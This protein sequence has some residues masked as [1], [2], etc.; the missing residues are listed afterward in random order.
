MA[1]T[2]IDSAI[3]ARRTRIFNILK[4]LED[5]PKTSVTHENNLDVIWIWHENQFVPGF[6]LQWCSNKEHY[7]VYIYVACKKETDKAEAGYSICTV[8][9]RLAAVGFAAM[10]SFLHKHRAHN[11]TNSYEAAA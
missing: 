3:K 5:L 7:R 8:G 6:K 2:I 11:K 4:A 9:S 1:L 10:F